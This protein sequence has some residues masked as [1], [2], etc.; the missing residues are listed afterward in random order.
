MEK[1]D[2]F[3]KLDYSGRWIRDS[4]SPLKLGDFF[5]IIE[6]DMTKSKALLEK[7][8]N[9][10]INASYIQIIVRATAIILTKHPILHELL[11]SRY[12]LHPS[13]VDIGLAV[14]G[15]SIR[16]PLLII[17]N[18][19]NK[20]VEEIANE[21][22]NRKG[23]VFIQEKKD[24]ELYRKWGWLVPF[25]FLRRWMRRIIARQIRFRQRTFG[26]FQITS[27]PNI[28]Q[29]VPLLLLT[30]ASL[31]VGSIQDRVI[32]VE[33]KPEVR[34]T[35]YLSCCADHKVWDGARMNLFLRSMKKLLESDELEKEL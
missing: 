27:L 12:L 8:Q 9:K 24:L 23:E 29:F 1:D 34:P 18:A 13:E 28:D 2:K 14:V 16:A 10:G 35:V 25:G 3:E 15:R 19:G 5:Q 32:A 17:K 7:M 11:S 30:T 26:T 6:V 33:G 4:L 31:G 21:I 20:N 22:I